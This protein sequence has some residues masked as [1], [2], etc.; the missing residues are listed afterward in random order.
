M[1]SKTIYI[2]ILFVVVA[3]CRDM[4]AG[5]YPYAEIYRF[6]VSEDTLIHFLAEMKEREHYLPPE[7]LQLSDGK[8][9]SLDHWY[10]IYFFDK[11][12]N[13]VYKTWVRK[14]DKVVTKFAFVSIQSLVTGE[15]KR[16]NKDFSSD[17]NRSKLKAFDKTILQKIPFKYH[18]N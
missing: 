2:I 14:E 11:E 10:H 1:K 6:D 17:Q 9:D 4:S 5:S 7:Y 15:F 16:I 13:E 18:G 8:R 12:K 3:S